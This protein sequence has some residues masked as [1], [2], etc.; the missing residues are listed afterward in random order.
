MPRG[1]ARRGAGRKKKTDTPPSPPARSAL[2]TRDKKI[3]S[4]TSPDGKRGKRGPAKGAKY[5]PTLQKEA[6][7]E[8]LRAIV[9]AEMQ[10]LVSAQLSNAKGI[11]YLV[12]RSKRTG[13]FVR[14]TEAMAKAKSPDGEL[15]DDEEVIEVW[16]KDPSVQAFT[17]LLNRALDKPKEQEQEINLHVQMDM[18]DQLRK[19]RLRAHARNA[20][21]S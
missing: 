21:R 15:A 16:E 19:A 11:K 1:G 2:A 9:L 13:K 4:E 18:A 7:R 17:D 3:T 6:A 14:V 5:K 12:T 10:E 8:A 20:A